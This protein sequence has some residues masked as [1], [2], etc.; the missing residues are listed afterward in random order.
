M[1]GNYRQDEYGFYYA[2]SAAYNP[3]GYEFSAPGN[4]FP[5]DP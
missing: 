1:A 2:E 3:P 5:A 4:Q